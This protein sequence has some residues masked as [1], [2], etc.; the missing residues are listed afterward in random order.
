M[1]IQCLLYPLRWMLNP[2]RTPFCHQP[3]NCDGHRAHSAANAPGPNP[4]SRQSSRTA[5]HPHPARRLGSVW[6]YALRAGVWF[7]RGGLCMVAPDSQATACPPSGRN[8]T[9]RPVQISETA[10]TALPQ[11]VRKVARRCSAHVV[12]TVPLNSWKP[13]GTYRP[14]SSDA[15]RHSNVGVVRR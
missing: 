4:S 14:G 1:T 3:E 15:C 13:G 9:Y 6:C 5:C 7:R 12:V 11:L 8:S 2:P 10:L